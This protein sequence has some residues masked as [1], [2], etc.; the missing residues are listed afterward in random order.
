MP[1][2][3]I[4]A[5]LRSLTQQREQVVVAGTTVRE[6]ID[7]LE[8]QFPGLR[9]RLCLADQLRPGMIVAID[10][11]VSRRGLDQPVAVDS[12]VHFLPAVG[13]GQTD[14]PAADKRLRHHAFNRPTFRA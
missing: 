10:S 7:E 3:W 5:P 11:E 2:V 6:V 1:T 13:G 14:S 4:P 9:A 8:R 12:E